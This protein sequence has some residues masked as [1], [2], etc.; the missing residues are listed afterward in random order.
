MSRGGGGARVG[1]AVLSLLGLLVGVGLTAWLSSRV[2]DDRPGGARSGPATSLPE[3]PDAGVEV[4]VTP[5]RDLDD[6]EVV[7]VASSAFPAGATVALRQCLTPSRGTAL[8]LGP[9]G[10]CDDVAPPVV[11]VV[12]ARG[13]FEA[14]LVVRG[15]VTVGGLPF[16]CAESAGFCSVL[17]STEEPTPDG[18]ATGGP[19]PSEPTTGAAPLAFAPGTRPQLTLPSG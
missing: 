19:A 2:L 11:A 8:V 4:A 1:C 16:D 12:D 5:A 14:E 15:V 3:A 10:G 13:R 18:S 9:G 6:G 7:R 17:A